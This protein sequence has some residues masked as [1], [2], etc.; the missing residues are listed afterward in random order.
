MVFQTYAVWPH[1]RGRLSADARNLPEALLYVLTSPDGVIAHLA[2]GE[3]AE[4]L[5]AEVEVLRGGTDAWR[6][7][8]RPVTQDAPHYASV[9]DDV[10]LKAFEQSRDREAAMR[11]YLQWELDL[12]AQIRTDRSVN[13]R[14]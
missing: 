4:A 6:E 2:K 8:G 14:L 12:V 13:F 3:L 11:E 7:A 1:M 10:A 5:G 9:K